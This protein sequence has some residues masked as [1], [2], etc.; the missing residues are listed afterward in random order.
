MRKIFSVL[1]VAVLAFSSCE[2]WDQVFTTD[3]GEADVYEPVT[4]TPNTTIA[5]LKA[6]YKTSPV[7]IDKNLIIGGQVVSED[8]T[9]NIYKSLYIQD[10]TGG[11]ELKI[12]KSGLYNDY[13]LGQWVYVKCSG[14][15][16][17]AYNG[18]LQLGYKDPTGEY[19]T[20][21]LDVQYIIDTHVFRGEV[22]TPLEA[23]KVSAN[24]L[25][26]E[27]NIGCYVEL[28]GL[29]YGNEIFL[30][31]YV[32]QNGDKKS[33]DNRIFFSDETW[34][35]T[36]WAMSK[37]GFLGYLNSGAF[38]AGATNTGRKVTE[39]KKT[40]QKNATAYTVSQYFR[41]GVQEVQ[42]RTSG[43]SRFADT[44]ID[45]EILNGKKINV[46]GILTTYNNASQFTLIDLGGI[47]IVD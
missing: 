44:Q 7:K 19:E 33:N 27:E 13:K 4:M 22:D 9:G 3:Y 40:L 37:N 20:S 25:L 39:L 35:V 26:K 10:A 15:T 5:E 16:L 41:M 14:L 24:D 46:K 17:G 12:G 1:A 34:G 28:D 23:K 11:I 38:D 32:D 6:L 43:Y 45:P 47:E 21:Y 2:E 8:R 18:M 29:T 31:V 30:L 36:T 42:I